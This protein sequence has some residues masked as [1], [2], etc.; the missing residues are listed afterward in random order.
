MAAE[1]P[2]KVETNAVDRAAAIEGPLSEAPAFLILFSVCASIFLGTFVPP[3][4]ALAVSLLLAAA[5]VFACTKRPAEGWLAVVAIVFILAALFSL[6]SLYVINRKTALPDTVETS[7]RVLYSRRWGH[8]KALLI[9]TPYG[10]LAGYVP[11]KDAPAEGSG[12]ALRGA[13]FDFKRAERRGG[14]D[15]TL[16]WRS[17]GAV[18]KIVFFEIGETSPPAG[19]AKWRAKLE[20]LI[21]ERLRP[22]SASYMAAFTVGRRDSPIEALHKRA[23]TSHLLAVSGLHV[24][25]IAGIFI[26]LLRGNLTRFFVIS[27]FVWGYL[28][29]SGL[30]IGGVRAAVMIEL[31]LAALVLGRPPAAFNNVSVAAVLLL[32]ANPW[33]F[34]D[35]GWRLSVVC[36]LFISAVSS[37]EMVPGRAVSLPVLLWF[38]TAPLVTRAFG[39]APLA[40][41]A[42]NIIAVPAFGVIFPLVLLFSLP[43][44]L[45]LPFSWVAAESSEAILSF[46]QRA[47]ELGADLLPG[48][49]GW[50]VPQFALSVALFAACAA[51][52]CGAGLKRASIIS[53]IFV[54]FLFYCPSM[55]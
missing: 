28:L 42:L 20:A 1:E 41:L 19:L 38:V 43:P 34:F 29:L 53:V 37:L 3:P 16:Y 14:F 13:L 7:G 25:M 54:L 8:G 24:W 5:L 15:E 31:L 22:L 51:L 49:V 18:K 33:Y 50:G 46:F 27:L 10:K 30:P 45:G 21:Y 11:Q 40:G 35:L 36:A 9:A 39:E 52:R 26:L 4:V 12:V 23:G 44:L 55:L 48:A 32:L 6:Y 17:R 47:L 2:L